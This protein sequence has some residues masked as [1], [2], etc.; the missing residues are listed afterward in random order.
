MGEA[1][2]LTNICDGGGRCEGM[3]KAAALLDDDLVD[4]DS[5]N[6]TNIFEKD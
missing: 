5:R 6:E 4:S 1:C 2:W 3:G